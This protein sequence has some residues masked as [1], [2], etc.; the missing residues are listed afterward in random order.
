M[1]WVAI[2]E[3]TARGLFGEQ[4]IYFGL[5]ALG[6]NIHFGYTG[7]LNLGQAVFMAAGAYGLSMS[8]VTLGLNFWWGLLLGIIVFPLILA[9]IMGVPTLRL[10]ADYLAIVTIAAS[11][12]F[13]IIAR[14][15]S[16]DRWTGSSDG[17]TGFATTFYDLSPYDRQER[18]LFNLFIGNQ[19]WV[20]TVG[21]IALVIG[22]LISLLLMKSPWGRVLKAIREDED[23]ARSLGK[24][25]YWYK[26]QAL[27]IGGVFGAMGGMLRAIGT[28]SAQPQNFITDVTFFAWVALILGGA[29]KVLGPIVG[30]AILY[31]ILS[32]SD[33]ALRQLVDNGHVPEWLMTGTQVGQVRFMLIGLGLILLAA[34]RP[35]GIFGNKEEM[36]LDDR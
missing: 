22:V 15:P 10:R 12:M 33:V 24:N 8:V 1:D 11:E 26:M 34:F 23:A 35:Q 18:Y 6:L 7:L 3:N 28:Q 29:A 25:A 27:M 32:F 9:A 19:M 4:F 30:A 14:S 21:W 16:L 2:I 17:L 13:R 20:V 31:A 5:A 36:A